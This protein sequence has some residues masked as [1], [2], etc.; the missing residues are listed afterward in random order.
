MICQRQL[1]KQYVI[2]VYFIEKKT[3]SRNPTFLLFL[4]ESKHFR[5]LKHCIFKGI[6]KEFIQ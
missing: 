6:F 5:G 3:N 1:H 2:N 4:I